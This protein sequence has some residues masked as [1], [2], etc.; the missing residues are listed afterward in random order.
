M[1]QSG[2][3]PIQL[4]RTATASAAPSAGNLAD[5]E[6]AINTNDGLLFYK[7]SGGVVRTIAS[8]ARTSGVFAPGTVSAPGI[9]FTGDTNTGIYSPAADTIAFTEGGVEAMRLDA[10]GNVG[11]GTTTPTAPLDVN[12]NVAI[13]GTARRITG[14]FSNGTQASRVLF[15]TSTAGS[16]TAL[17]AI[18]S[19]G[20]VSS[21]FNAFNSSDPNNASFFQFRIGT[22][23]GDARLNSSITGTGTY[24]PITFHAGASERMR[25]DTS[26][27]VGIGTTTPGPFGRLE[28][29]G[30]GYAATAVQSSDASGVVGAF[31]ANSSSELR[32]A[33]VTNHPLTLLTNNLERMRIGASG[34]VG[35]GTSSPGYPLDIQADA[36]A[37]GWTIRGRSADS[38]AVGRFA[39]N[40]NVDT[41][42]L[43]AFSD[44]TFTISNTSSATERMRIDPVGNVGIGTSSPAARLQSTVNTNNGSI[45]VAAILD[46]GSQNP[47][48]SGGGIAMNFRTNSGSSFFGGVGGYTDG[49]NYV[50]GLWGG[51]AASGAPALAVT[52]AGNV[53]I[54]TIATGHRLVVAGN[55]TSDAY[56]LRASGSAPSADAAIYRP[57]DNTLGFVTGSNERARITSD[58]EFLVGVASG[59]GG[60]NDGRVTSRGISSRSGYNGSF[61]S[62]I[63]NIHWTGTAQLW[64]DTTN[65]GTIAF[66]SDYRIKRNIETQAQPALDRV[67]QLRPVTYQM[68]DYGNIIKASDDVREGFIAHEL[69][70][71]IP[72]AVS[73]EKDA[74]DQLQSLKLDA[75]CSVLVKAIQEQQA[76]IEELKARVAALENN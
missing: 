15:Q 55:T 59:G 67:L 40:A 12:G 68:A 41:A 57:A 23:Q 33:A 2:F 49:T 28:V 53:G 71:V 54:G 64:I 63:I 66:T 10:S 69:A 19:A 75:L 16:T 22:D 43:I 51:A 17:G 60:A 36:A 11:I 45:G 20:G 35:I 13:T 47:S 52:S 39:T 62:N 38:V 46:A 30:A 5:G 1:A 76:Q 61:S 9:T 37:F 44:G 26:G 34:N 25:I 27:N 6:L 7:D 31:A 74:A 48:V 21:A 58:G 65:V 73:G 3:T 4:Y 18:P 29:R 70:A 32:V 50:A 24:L 56:L 42:R 14:D 8:A 72:S